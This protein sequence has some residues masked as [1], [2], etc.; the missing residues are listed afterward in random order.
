MSSWTYVRGSITVDVPGRTQP[1]IEY[2]LKTVIDHLPLVTGSEE[3]MFVNIMKC[4][5]SN[6]SI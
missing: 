3:N 1:E 5:G 2:I 4:N 6:S